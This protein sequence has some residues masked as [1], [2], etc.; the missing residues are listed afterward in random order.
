M[1]VWVCAPAVRQLGHGSIPRNTAWAL[2]RLHL[3]WYN[4]LKPTTGS[5]ACP[6]QTDI[7]SASRQNWY[8]LQF[9]SNTSRIKSSTSYRHAALSICSDKL[10][11]F[12][13]E[14]R[15]CAHTHTHTHTH[16]DKHSTHT[17]T[18]KHSTHT[19]THTHTHQSCPNFKSEARERGSRYRRV[20]PGWLMS[21]NKCS[22]TND[23]GEAKLR[24]RQTFPQDPEVSP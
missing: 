5:G 14:R 7:N 22:F 18:D 4:C 13:C 24:E 8:Q 17:H 2:L 15:K 12:L 19:H 20:C 6:P 1:C 16:T 21:C 9:D 3:A 10:C 11:G 23:R